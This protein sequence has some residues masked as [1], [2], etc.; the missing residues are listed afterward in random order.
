M[1]RYREIGGGEKRGVRQTPQA[2]PQAPPL[3]YPRTSKLV[4]SHFSGKPGGSQ[5]L[6]LLTR[7]TLTLVD[8]SR[9]KKWLRTRF[10]GRAVVPY[11]EK[12]TKRL[13]I[14]VPPGELTG[15]RSG[16]LDRRQSILARGRLQSWVASISFPSKDPCSL[17]PRSSPFT[18][19]RLIH[20]WSRRQYLPGG[21]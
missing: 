10:S 3:S 20:S 9:K 7:P 2:P 5:P 6:T 12:G 1:D 14:L 15:V 8:V 21:S 13:H 17:P 18:A 4:I 16:Y 19:S 11:T